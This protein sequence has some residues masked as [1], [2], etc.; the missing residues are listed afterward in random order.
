MSAAPLV[1]GVEIGGTKC[2]AILGRSPGDVVEEVRI[3]T[4]APGP[5]LKAMEEVLE[6]WQ[7]EHGFAAIGVA[8]FG[9]L[10]LD[11]DAADYSTIVSTPKPGWSGTDILHRWKR[12]GVPVALQVDVIGA[13]MAE[14]RWGAAQGL[15]D[16]VY[17]TVGTGIGVGP[18]IADACRINSPLDG[19]T[20]SDAELRGSLAI[21]LAA[22]P[23]SAR[24]PGLT[25]TRL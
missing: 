24:A 6:R 18:I 25:M 16:F 12:F 2:I 9:P 5:T 3:D 11:S 4:A 1:A 19:G 7:A 13:A 14:Q 8:S 15:Q 23:T 21:S 20:K 17:I 22:I 10:R